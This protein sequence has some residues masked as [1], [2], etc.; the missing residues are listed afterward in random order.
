[1]SISEVLFFRVPQIIQTKILGKNQLKST[2]KLLD[3]NKGFKTTNYLNRRLN[4]S[5]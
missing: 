1:M 5:F 4:N 2:Y 3:L